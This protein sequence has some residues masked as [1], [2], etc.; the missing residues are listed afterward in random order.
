MLRRPWDVC[1]ITLGSTPSSLPIACQCFSTAAVESIIVPSIKCY[2]CG[3]KFV[4]QLGFSPSI[5][6]SKPLKVAL[7]GGREKDAEFDPILK[8]FYGFDLAAIIGK[9]LGFKMQV[10]LLKTVEGLL[11]GGVVS[12]RGWQ[13]VETLRRAPRQVRSATKFPFGL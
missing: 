8:K 5:S 10:V 2:K 6:K 12:K 11:R 1:R 4:S 3:L 13:Q 9:S 7:W